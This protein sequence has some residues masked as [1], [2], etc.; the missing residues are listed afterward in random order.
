MDQLKSYCVVKGISHIYLWASEGTEDI[1]KSLAFSKV[2]TVDVA[3]ESFLDTWGFEPYN[4]ATLMVH[5][6][7]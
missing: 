7:P 1:Y 5:Y 6:F 2:P 3:R 4:H